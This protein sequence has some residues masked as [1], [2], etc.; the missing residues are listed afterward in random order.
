MTTDPLALAPCPFCHSC[1]VSVR[2]A[3]DRWV[4]CSSCGAEGPTRLTEVEAIAAWNRRA[5]PVPP[6][7]SEEVVRTIGEAIRAKQAGVKMPNSDFVFVDVYAAARAALAA[8]AGGGEELGSSRASR[9]RSQTASPQAQHSD[10]GK[11]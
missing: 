2:Q 1:S 9:A 10:G 11:G 7:V 4:L 5:A 8:M 3:Q 6:V